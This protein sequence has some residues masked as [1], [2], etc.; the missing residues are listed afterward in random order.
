MSHLEKFPYREDVVVIPP[1]PKAKSSDLDLVLNR[2]G[3]N[4]HTGNTKVVVMK[5][6]KTM[7]GIETNLVHKFYL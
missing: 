4:E 7:Q 2:S 1:H 5:S 3:D 6:R